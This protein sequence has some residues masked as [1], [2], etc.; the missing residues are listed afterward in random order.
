MYKYVNIISILSL[1]IQLLLF[2]FLNSAFASPSLL[3]EVDTTKVS[4]NSVETENTLSTTKAPTLWIKKNSVGIN[5]N[6]VSFINWSSGGNN[7]IS[8]LLHGK[9]ERNYNKKLFSWRNSSSFRL[10]LNAQEGRELRKSEDQIRINS[11]FGYRR[12]STSNFRYS[13]KLNFN[14]QLAQGYKYPNKEKFISKFM[15]PGYLFIG[16]G[17]EYSYP[18]ED[19]TIYLSPLTQKSTF[20]LDDTLANK[21]MYGVS[22]AIK[23]LE[24]NLIRNGEK[25]ETEL[26][27]LVTSEFTKEI[28]TRMDLN[29]HIILYSDYINNFGNVDVDWQLNVD[30]EIND[31]LKA[32]IGTHLRYDEDVKVRENVNGDGKTETMTAKI[33]FKQLL[34]VGVAFEL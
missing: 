30:M 24:G 3:V 17:T 4:K 27:I 7:S 21:G 14:T 19:L 2:L 26:G 6:E 15:A 9:L 22:A 25:V 32:S 1:K 28:F 29:N 13:A 31:F 23:D 10:G 33:Q 12:D 16:L 11:T 8:A 20:V 34:G 5:F 18:H